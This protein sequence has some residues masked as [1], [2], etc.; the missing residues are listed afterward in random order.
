M[1]RMLMGPGHLAHHGTG[2][3]AV[4]SVSGLW[5]HLGA[6]LAS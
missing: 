6:G 4:S 5:E 2:D 3:H 1:A